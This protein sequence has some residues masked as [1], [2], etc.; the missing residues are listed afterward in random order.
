MGRATSANRCAKSPISTDSLAT[1]LGNTQLMEQKGFSP[2][3]APR[4]RDIVRP[5]GERVSVL[6]LGQ[7]VRLE[8]GRGNSH[9]LDF[10]LLHNGKETTL[11]QLILDWGDNPPAEP[12]NWPELEL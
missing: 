12:E 2:Y 7:C 8:T 9:I 11:K 6:V 4:E 3:E 1:R 10:L 5:S